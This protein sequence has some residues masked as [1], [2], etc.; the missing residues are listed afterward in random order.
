M[1]PKVV[2]L[3]LILISV[4][5]YFIGIK[6][7][8]YP[9]VQDFS[10]DDLQNY[11][12]PLCD[13][14]RSGRNYSK[15]PIIIYKNE[16]IWNTHTPRDYYYWIKGLPNVECDI[17]C[18]FT[19]NESM[20]R[21]YTDVYF[22]GNKPGNG[23]DNHSLNFYSTMESPVRFPYESLE[24]LKKAGYDITATMELDSDI[25]ML[26]MN[27]RVLNILKKS[28]S[29]PKRDDAMMSFFISNCRSKDRLDYL[30]EL[31]KYNVTYHSFGKC[32][33]NMDAINITGVNNS[34]KGQIIK[35]YKFYFCFENS[36][37]KDYV[38]EKVY[39][40][41]M[42][43][44][45]PIYYGA[46]NFAD[47]VPKNSVVNVRAFSSPKELADYLVMLSN[48]ETEYNKY[49]AWRKDFN[50]Y[51]PRRMK[52][53]LAFESKKMLCR[54]CIRAADINRLKYGTEWIPEDKRWDNIAVVPGKPSKYNLTGLSF[55]FI[56]F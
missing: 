30:K 23:C 45:V 8:N 10:S 32:L 33:H 54:A 24:N 3:T 36:V 2:F 39:H 25:P 11:F 14:H 17:P 13:I 56:L 6:Y 34:D 49:H 7:A 55:L 31:V 41:L 42:S 28:K 22:W 20:V 52:E 43:G 40:A 12:E 38:T 50:R 4:P 29:Y 35:H 51:I 15:H 5:V 18:I 1:D 9:R 16:S 27:K 37:Y 48:N 19:W 46:P 47:F 21:N 26:Y 44:T 53:L